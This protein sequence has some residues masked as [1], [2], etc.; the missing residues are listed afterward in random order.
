ML[1]GGNTSH[2]CQSAISWAKL[3]ILRVSQESTDV[4]TVSLMPALGEESAEG[5]SRFRATLRSFPN[6]FPNCFAVRQGASSTPKSPACCKTTR[7]HHCESGH[8]Y[9][10]TSAILHSGNQRASAAAPYFFLISCLRKE[11]PFLPYHAGAIAQPAA[12]RRDWCA[13]QS[14]SVPNVVSC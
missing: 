10:G 14:Q 4:R 2:E 1:I 5:T 7:K 13:A 6:C 3:A 12:S 8:L 9:C 11:I